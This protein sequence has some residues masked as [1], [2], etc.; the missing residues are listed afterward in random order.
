M[1]LP[2]WQP[3]PMAV[4]GARRLHA[5]PH[6]Q[7]TPDERLQIMF[8]AMGGV[9]IPEPGGW[10]YVPFIGPAWETAYDLQ[11]GDYADAA[12]NA[13]MLAAEFTPAAPLRRVAKIV[14]DINRS[15]RAPLLAR[16]ATQRAR[17]RKIV[18]AE[19]THIG[20]AYE[21]HHTIPFKGLGPIPKAD[22]KAEG[23]WRNHP[24]N[25]KIL[26]KEVHA[27][28]HSTT[29]PYGPLLQTWHGTNALQKSGA[30]ATA[31]SG[32]DAVQNLL[33]EDDQRRRR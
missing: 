31:A 11:E 16:D 19:K 2:P 1:S 29:N 32:V 15:R 14:R 33:R 22:R 10:G 21:V 8:D 25:L 23:L 13:A 28:L 18:N 17:I 26:P 7:R 5:I 4:G 27:R 20:K 24:A 9:R 6:A 30:A 12:F 3:R